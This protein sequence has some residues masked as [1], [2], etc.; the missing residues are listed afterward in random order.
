MKINMIGVPLDLRAGRRGFD[1]RPSAVR[2][3]G[4]A[5]RLR[6]L[7]H[8]VL[9]EGDIPT[10]V[11]VLQRIRNERLKYLPQVVR[12][13]SLLATKTEKSDGLSVCPEIF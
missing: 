2:L 12:A 3:A 10:K 13:C 8:T 4:V 11:P 6:M 1:M 5:D 7:G 9:D